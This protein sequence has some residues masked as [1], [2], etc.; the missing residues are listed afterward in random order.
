MVEVIGLAETLAQIAE[1]ARLQMTS[2]VD[3]SQALR[4]EIYRNYQ[5]IDPDAEE[6]EFVVH[7]DGI[8]I[9]EPQASFI[10]FGTSNMAP[11]PFIR[12]A[13]EN[14]RIQREMQEAIAHEAEHELGRVING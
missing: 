9:T 10:E 13:I 5:R 1:L 11:R 7:P 6:T 4:D 3:A 14:E 2:S 12:P 8:E